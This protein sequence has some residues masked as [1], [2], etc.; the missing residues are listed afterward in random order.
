MGNQVQAVGDLDLRVLQRF[1]QPVQCLRGDDVAALDRYDLAG[2]DGLVGDE[3]ASGDAAFDAL[4]R[5]RRD[6]GRHH[7]TKSRTT[8]P[9]ERRPQRRGAPGRCAIPC[10]S[11]SYLER[12]R[13]AGRLVGKSI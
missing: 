11:C 7:S 2:V 6:P 10:S 3:S 13:L 4:A 5:F 12:V 9:S 8:G 1:A